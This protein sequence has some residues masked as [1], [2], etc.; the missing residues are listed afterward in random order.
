MKVVIFNDTSREGHSGCTQL[1]QNLLDLCKDNGVMVLGSF[2][3]DDI[4]SSNEILVKHVLP[5]VDF[6]LIN[7]E[8]TFHRSPESVERML[9]L[10]SCKPIALI[11]TLWSRM[12]LPAKLLKKIEVVWVRES[13]SYREAFP[14]FGEEKLSVVPDLLFLSGGMTLPKV[15]FGDSVMDVPRKYLSKCTNY[16][17]I[18]GEATKPDFMARCVW[19]RSLGLFVTGRFHDVVLA[20]MLGVPFVSVVSNSHKIEGLL[21]DMECPELLLETLDGFVTARETAVMGIPKAMA[22]A[23]K[24]PGRI[25]SAF[26]DLLEVMRVRGNGSNSNPE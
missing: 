18:Q 25:R 19:M 22:Y 23:E 4:K 26:K 9:Q 24:A 15:G 10:A 16:F 11:N 13:R 17:P 2:C 3:R 20:S 6:V 14:I 8:G 1:M 21:E 12:V 7:G 5:K